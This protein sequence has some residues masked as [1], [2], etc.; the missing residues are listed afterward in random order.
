MA[1][2]DAN[3]NFRYVKVGAQGSISDAGVFNNCS[4]SNALERDE[5]NL[6]NSAAIPGSNLVVPYMILT[7]DAFPLKTYHKSYSRRGIVLEE[8]IFNYR[9][10][11][12]RR[13]VENAFGI[14]LCKFQMFR[15]PIALKTSY[16]HIIPV[17]LAAICL[18]NFLRLR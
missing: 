17:V 8:R 3:Y 5:L 4:L 6:Q 7:D 9:L 10:S 15:S 11:R 2:V 12:A 18:H 1:I 14:L 13:V 16:V